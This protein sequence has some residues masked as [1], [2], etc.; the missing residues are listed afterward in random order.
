M[1]SGY[2]RQRPAPRLHALA[3]PGWLRQ[4]L[5]LKML[6]SFLHANLSAQAPGLPHSS[7]HQGHALK[8]HVWDKP[9][10]LAKHSLRRED[11]LNWISHQQ[12]AFYSIV[13]ILLTLHRFSKGR[14]SES[15]WASE[16]IRVLGGGHA[17]REMDPSL[18]GQDS[19]D[20]YP[21]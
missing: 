9:G 20:L 4:A 11:V 18:Q 3:W 17:C 1:L 13:P 8:H 6:V 21:L 7:C 12:L 14:G 19:T 16:H 2:P 10:S 5:N 15:F